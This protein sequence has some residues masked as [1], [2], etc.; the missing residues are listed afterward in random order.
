[1]TIDVPRIGQEVARRSSDAPS[2]RFAFYGRVSTED[3]QDPVAS[4]NWQLTRAKALIEPRG[5]LIAAEYFDIGDSRSTPWWRRP[6]A[7]ALLE[8]LTDP[9]RGFD[10]IAIGEPQRA[11]HGNQYGLTMPL[12]THYG[13]QLWVPEVGGAIEPDS[14]AHD[15]IMSVFGGISKGERSRVKIRVRAA[16]QAQARIEGR[17]LGGRPPYGYRLA[18][19]GP[20]PNPAKAADGKRLHQ[21][22]SDPFTSAAVKRIFA[23]Y[24]AA[25]PGPD[26]VG[27]MVSVREGTPAPFPSMPAGNRYACSEGSRSPLRRTTADA[28]VAGLLASHCA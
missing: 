14:E 19:A 12:I 3:N 2:L 15:L 20:H 5:G 22:E 25:S 21:L 13:L 23:L 10:A 27:V 16:M 8:A 28:C 26:P 7:T 11:F 24:L 18:D 6:C 4:R 9:Q 17:F 1:V